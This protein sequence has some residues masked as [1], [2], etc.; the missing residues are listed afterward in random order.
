MRTLLV[1]TSLVLDLLQTWNIFSPFSIQY[2]AAVHPPTLSS[3]H[4]PSHL[5]FIL[6]HSHLFQF[7]MVLPV[8]KDLLHALLV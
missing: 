4:Y 2:N 8:V 6:F 5:L 7:E 3:R 1:Q